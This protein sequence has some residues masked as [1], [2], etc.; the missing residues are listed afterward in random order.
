[1]SG[2]SAQRAGGRGDRPKTEGFVLPNGRIH[3]PDDVNLSA[4]LDRNVAEYGDQLAY[5]YVDYS[6]DPDGKF[7]ELTW[8]QVGVRSRAIASRL[9]QVTARGDRVA[10]LAP[11]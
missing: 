6:K 5:R 7:V 10:I 8:H 2:D 1:M 4:L 3:I 11:Q 9:Q